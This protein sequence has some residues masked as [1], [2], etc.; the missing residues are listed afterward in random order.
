MT[1]INLTGPI[2]V[3][4]DGSPWADRALDWAGRQALVSR[5]QL[6]VVN[7]VGLPSP[8]GVTDFSSAGTEYR[9]LLRSTA[10]DLVAEA[11]ERV[12]ADHGVS[13]VASVV[14]MTD[15]REALLEAAAMA[16]MLVVGAR[17]LGPI[18]QLLLGSVSQAM[19]KH[20]G[21]PVVVVRS[22]HQR[23]R[24]AGV[25]VAVSGDARDEWVLDFAFD[26]AASRDL[27]VTLLHAFWDP[28]RT[29]QGDR[30]VADHETGYDDERALL[31]DAARPW[32]VLHPTV[33]V[34]H[35]LVRGFADA[36]LI[37]VSDDA[38]LLVLGHRR[39]PFLQEVIYGSVAPR[40]VEHARCSSAVV[41]VGEAEDPEPEH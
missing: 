14:R 29:A 7:A 20:A 23:P 36:Q 17:G 34:R 3:G 10:E 37:A 38:E 24:E 30:V 8:G 6:V 15:P 33:R 31:S 4:F 39:K 2:V 13:D 21:A 35:R 27:P 12:R 41:P 32:S 16:S 40:V 19:I 22:A 9:Q 5:R 18:R 11:V 28:T 26:V 1:S 25:V